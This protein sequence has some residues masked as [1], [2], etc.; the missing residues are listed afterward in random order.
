M[1]EKYKSAVN[2]LIDAFFIVGATTRSP[3][4]IIANNVTPSFQEALPRD[5]SVALRLLN[6]TENIGFV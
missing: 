5:V 4:F 3:A 6:M 1:T 2:R